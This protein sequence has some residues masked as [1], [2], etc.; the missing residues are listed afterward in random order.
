MGQYSCE[1]E[2]EREKE[3]ERER[4]KKVSSIPS[5]AFITLM[6]ALL[7]CW[8]IWIT[9]KACLPAQKAET[10]VVCFD[11]EKSGRDRAGEGGM[12]RERGS[13]SEGENESERNGVRLWQ[14][15]TQSR[16]FQNIPL[17][18]KGPLKEAWSLWQR[19]WLNTK[20]F[21]TFIFQGD[22]SE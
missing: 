2:R 12:E 22:L 10:T 15:Q 4:G 19:Q 8:C 13:V 6:Y 1:R 5:T 3:R 18:R 11:V 20:S 21:K 17:R 9:V 14:T 16:G 7:F